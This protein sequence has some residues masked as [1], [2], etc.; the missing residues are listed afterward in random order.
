MQGFRERQTQMNRRLPTPPCP[1]RDASASRGA[2]APRR[3]RRLGR[4]RVRPAPAHRQVRRR[5]LGADHR[6]ADRESRA[7]APPRAPAQPPGRLRRA[8]LHRHRLGASRGGAS[9]PNDPGPLDRHRQHRRGLGLAAVELPP[10][11]R[12][13]D[14]A[15]AH[16]PRWNRRGRRLE[17]PDR[18]PGARAPRASKSRC[19]TPGSPTATR[20]RRLPPQP[21]LRLGQFAQ[22]YDFVDRDR[23]PLDENG[24]G[25]HVAGTIA[26]KTNNGIG[27]T[28][29]AYRAKLMPVRVLDSNG[30]GQADEIAN[31]IRF[32]V[33]HGADVIN[34]SFNFGCG[35][36][37]AGRRRSACARPTARAWS[38]SP[39]S[40]TSARRPASRR[41]RPAPG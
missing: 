25:T 2:P 21:R 9:L 17:E 32:A 20:A 27:L 18:E 26:E 16:L 23:L 7:R 40:A 10:L 31:G 30:S 1:A 35:K 38:R 39:R 14:P 28:G 15:A 19:S 24:H 41:P 36:R 29:L 34:M 8:R 13:G 11:G 4:A 3:E 22:G 12:T 33:N 6:P 37:G 5:A